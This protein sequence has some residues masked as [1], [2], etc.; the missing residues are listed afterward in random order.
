MDQAIIAVIIAFAV[1]GGVMWYK[2]GKM[3]QKL[4]DL[5]RDVHNNYIGKEG[6]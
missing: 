6:G 1:H 2:L 4:S 5:C 3:E